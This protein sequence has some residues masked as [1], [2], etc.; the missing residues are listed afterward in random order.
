MLESVIGNTLNAFCVTNHR[1]RQL[2]EDLK[3][4]IGC[5][6]P[7]LT[8]SD[9]TFDYSHGEPPQDVLTILRVIDV[10]DDFVLRRLVNA[11]HIECSALVERRVDGE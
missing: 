1:D 11:V 7:I 8:G 9:E 6:A 2:L 4:R 10:D 3:R 5:Q